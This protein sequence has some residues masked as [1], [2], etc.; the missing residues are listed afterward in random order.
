MEQENMALII[1][2]D[3]R[4]RLLDMNCMRYLMTGVCS[5]RLN[6]FVVF[7]L[8]VDI[9]LEAYHHDSVFER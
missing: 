1:Q 8:A 6:E 2:C 4:Y 9:L 5:I 7:C 3:F